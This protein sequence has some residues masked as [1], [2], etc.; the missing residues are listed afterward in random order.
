MRYQK[1]QARESDP[2][3]DGTAL[4]ESF[5][6]QDVCAGTDQDRARTECEQRA[7]CKSCVLHGTEVGSLVGR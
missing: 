6:E 4:A 7:Q 1:Q 5:V 3:R 2:D